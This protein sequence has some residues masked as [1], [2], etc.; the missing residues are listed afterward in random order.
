MTFPG[1]PVFWV[2][3][4]IPLTNASRNT[5]SPITAM[6]ATAVI[7]LVF[8]RTRTLR[9]LYASGTLPMV[10]R[11]SRSKRV[12]GQHDERPVLDH[13]R[14]QLL[15]QRGLHELLH[16]GGDIAGDL[17]LP[18]LLRLGH[19]ERRPGAGMKDRATT[20]ND[21]FSASGSRVTASTETARRVNSTT[22][23]A[24]S[25]NTRVSVRRSHDRL[26]DTASVSTD[27]CG[28][29]A[30]NASSRRGQRQQRQPEDDGGAEQPEHRPPEH[31][32]EADDPAVALE[33]AAVVGLAPQLHQRDRPA[34]RSP[35]RTWRAGPAGSG[36]GSPPPVRMTV[37]T[38][39]AMRGR[40][41]ARLTAPDS[42]NRAN[43][44][45]SRSPGDDGSIVPESAEPVENQATI[46]CVV[47]P[48]KTW[49]HQLIASSSRP[50]DAG[51]VGRASIPVRAVRRTPRVSPPDTLSP[52]SPLGRGVGGEGSGWWKLAAPLTPYPSP[53]RG[54]GATA[55]TPPGRTPRTPSPCGRS[56]TAAPPRPARPASPRIGP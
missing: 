42:M 18:L 35:G 34:A 49:R 21:P 44:H 24:T 51:A 15:V 50:T 16:V 20:A 2:R 17:L 55:V 6:N 13:G 8:H 23:P 36:P 53:Q 47:S 38:K 46:N 12:H 31:H 25:A 11:M 33:V 45:V 56:T 7:R 40:K 39:T 1:T 29:R 10:S 14:R 52:L 19:D 28:T 43:D 41:T 32:P 4:F 26:S 27:S 22:S 5:S 3:L 48:V 54:E 9:R 37:P 30:G